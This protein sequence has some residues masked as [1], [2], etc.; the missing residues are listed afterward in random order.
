MTRLD[1]LNADAQARPPDGQLA[2][3][4]QGMRGSKRHTVVAANVGGQ[5]AL[6]KKPFRHG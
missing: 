3:V 2:Q 5:A 1:A 6:S 4:E